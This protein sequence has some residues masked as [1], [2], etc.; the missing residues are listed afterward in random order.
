MLL[1][2]E[3]EDSSL[4]DEEKVHQESIKLECIHVVKSEFNAL[5]I[6]KPYVVCGAWDEKA[7]WRGKVWFNVVFWDQD[8]TVTLADSAN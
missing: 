5:F 4:L 7:W 6:G 8:K 1:I 3:N 2:S